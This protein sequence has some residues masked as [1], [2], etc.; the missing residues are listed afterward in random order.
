MAG[1]LDIAGSH[2]ITTGKGASASVARTGR[3]YSLR[4]HVGPG[5]GLLGVYN[6]GKRIRTINTRASA[7]GFRTV[8]FYSGTVRALRTFTF[9]N[10]GTS[11]VNL[12]GLYVA[13]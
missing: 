9:T 1:K 5:G 7:N 6:H 3:A 4:V 8:T 11:R 13:F 12:D 10:L 2:V